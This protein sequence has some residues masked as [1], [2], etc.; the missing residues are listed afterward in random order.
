MKNI[1]LIGL[2][3]CGKSTFGKRLARRLRMPLLDTDAMIEEAEGQ[4]ISTIFDERGEAYFRDLESAACLAVSELRGAIISTGGGMVL[5]EKNM[6]A[7]AKN[8]LIFFIDR[9]PSRILRS[10]SLGDRPLVQDDRDKLFRLYGERLAL[11]RRWADTTIRNSGTRRRMARCLRQIIKK[12]R[13]S[14]EQ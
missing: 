4:H 6:Q 5:R 12:F 13:Q 1:V 10:A 14:L 9:H 8:G 7:L 2:S 11:Y 3:G